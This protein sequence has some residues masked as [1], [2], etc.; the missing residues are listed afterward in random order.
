MRIFVAFVGCL[1]LCGALAFGEDEGTTVVATGSAFMKVRPQFLRVKILLIADGKD[2]KGALAALALQRE[3]AK[4]A[5]GALNPD[6][7]VAADDP[8]A[9][10]GPI[11]AQQRQALIDSAIKVAK[12]HKTSPLAIV[13]AV[14]TVEWSLPPASPDDA[15]VVA[16]ELEE[17]IKAAVPKHADAPRTPEEQEIYDEMQ[18]HPDDGSDPNAMKPDQPVFQFVHKMS[19]D[20]RARLT[21]DAAA[22]AKR[23]AAQL[24]AAAGRPLGALRCVSFAGEKVG[25]ENIWTNYL[26]T[27]T[28]Q[29][30]NPAAQDEVTSD[31]PQATIFSLQVSVKYSLGG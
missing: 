14:L 5:L 13:S 12:L 7:E 2:L 4:A 17:K 21:A 22:Q 25:D 31:G 3:T 10:P 6:A 19:D 18:N 20:E 30:D 29:P 23:G 1:L 11:S 9:G 16:T 26:R 27:L 24:A 28:G 15:L 8:V